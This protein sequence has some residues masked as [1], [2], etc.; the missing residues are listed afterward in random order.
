M[1]L[2]CSGWEP[3][4]RRRK[5]KPNKLGIGRMRYIWNSKFER[6]I[7]ELEVYNHVLLSA[8][9][10]VIQIARFGIFPRSMGKGVRLPKR[11]AHFIVDSCVLLLL[12]ITG[13]H[14]GVESNIGLGNFVNYSNTKQR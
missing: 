13:I 9:K 1:G 2:A 8:E 3:G 10:K 11:D 7:S 5:R 12:S 14:H 6:A 4:Q